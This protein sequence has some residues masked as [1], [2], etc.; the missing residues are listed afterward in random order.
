MPL[1]SAATSQLQR[2]EL[3]TK[4]K[5]KTL[6][7]PGAGA[8]CWD[9]CVP[10]RLETGNT[11]GTNKDLQSPGTPYFHA[12]LL[13]KQNFTARVLLIAW[14]GHMWKLRNSCHTFINCC[15]FSRAFMYLLLSKYCY[16]PAE[17]C[18]DNSEHLHFC[19]LGIMV[20]SLFPRMEASLLQNGRRESRTEQE[21]SCR[22]RQSGTAF[23]SPTPFQN[24]FDCCIQLMLVPYS[25]LQ[26]FTLS[27]KAWI[28]AKEM[29]SSACQSPFTYTHHQ[30]LKH[31]VSN[32]CS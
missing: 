19:S 1:A 22:P 6:H 8:L 12:L 16:L 18:S 11:C 2:T 4:K 23:C 17:L 24:R 21:M 25:F 13:E 28:F 7:K 20:V 5:H 14:Y 10:A 27:T 30:G 29:L 31:V 9:F 32:F 15:L 26:H 3:F